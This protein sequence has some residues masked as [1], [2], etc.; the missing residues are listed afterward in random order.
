[1]LNVDVFCMT[2]FLYS[3]KF[4]LSHRI[5]YPNRCL[6]KIIKNSIAQFV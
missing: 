3:L 5:E 1:M 4:V 6:R 2:L